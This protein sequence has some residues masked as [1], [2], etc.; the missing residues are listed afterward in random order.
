MGEGICPLAIRAW[1]WLIYHSALPP[2]IPAKAG[3]HRT[4]AM[5]LV[6]IRICGIIG[7]SGF[8][9]LVLKWQALIHIHLGGISIMAKKRGLGESEILP[10]LIL[11]RPR[12]RGSAG[13]TP[14]LPG[15]KPD[16]PS[17]PVNREGTCLSHSSLLSL[18]SSLHSPRQC[19]NMWRNGLRIQGG[20]SPC[21]FGL[22]LAG[23]FGR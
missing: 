13:G 8:Y 19:G 11:T 7:F 14:A 21:S 12:K 10:I 2:V 3:I 1:L 9:Q 22:R 5:R 15:R 20:W 4:R 23:C 16:A 17:Q 6:G 18:L